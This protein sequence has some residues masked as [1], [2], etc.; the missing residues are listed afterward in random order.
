MPTLAQQL[1]T[2]PNAMVGF[3]LANNSADVAERLAHMG[4]PVTND[5]D[6]TTALNALLDQGRKADFIT[7]LSVP[8]DPDAMPP[9]VIGVART[10]ATRHITS[11]GTTLVNTRTTGGGAPGVLRS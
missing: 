1:N 7:A 3:I 10:V 4:F 9:A 5:K 6:L 11:R 2:D 8:V